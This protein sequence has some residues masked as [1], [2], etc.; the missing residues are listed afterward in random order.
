M[1]MHVSKTCTDTA[2]ESYKSGREYR[3]KRFLLIAL[4]S[5]LAAC[6][7]CEDAPG[8]PETLPDAGGGADIQEMGALVC[9]DRDGD[10]YFSGADCTQAELDCNDNS[11]SINP[12]A[13]EVCGD[14]L[15]NNCADGVDETCPC[16]TGELRLCSSHGDPAALSGPEVRC[17]SGVQR[18]VEGAW[19]ETC[20]SEVGPAEETCNN[21]DD[22]CDG[23]ADEDLRAPTGE[24]LTPDYVPPPEDC[25]PTGE[26][27][28]FD[29]DGDGQVDEGCSCAVPD[30]D[31]NL[32]RTGQPCYS[33]PIAS[34][35]VG[36]CRS[37]T[38]SCQAGAWGQCTGDT[39]PAMEVCGD[40]LDNDCDGI[41]DNGCPTC[42]ATET[43][44][45]LC[46]G[47]DNDC[48]GVIDEGLRNGCGGCGP[49]AA[50]DTCG[51]GLDNNCDGQVDESCLCTSPQQP[52][53]PGPAEA[54]GVGSCVQGTQRCEGEFFGACNGAVLPGLELCG[55]TGMG[56]GEDEDCDGQVD[57][58]C[59]CSE[60]ATRPCGS[61]AGV[62]VYGTQTCA[63]GAWGTCEG[64]TGPTEAEEATC[65]G[66][67]N[68]CDG[69]E[70]EGLFNAC[71]ECGP[72]PEEVCDNQDNDCDGMVDEEV[73]NACGQCGPVP[74]EIC[75]NQDNDCDGLFDEGLQNACGDCGAL[76][77]EVCDG[78]DND[79]DDAVDEG[80]D[81]QCGD[82]AEANG[83]V[84]ICDG[85]DQDC[86]A[87]I[88]EGTR[89]DCN[90]CGEVPEEICDNRDNDCDGEVDEGTRNA[91]G[92]CGILPVDECN[93]A[94][95]DCDGEIDEDGLNA[96]NYCAA[97]ARETCDNIDNDC[98]G[99]VDDNAECP[100]EG[101]S[102]INGE[103]VGTCQAGECFNGTICRD[104]FC[105]TPCNNTDCSAGLVCQNGECGD[106]CEGI[107]CPVGL[108]CWLGACVAESCEVSGCPDGQVCDRGVCTDD[109]CA[110]AAC[111]DEQGC[112]AGSCFD[113][114]LDV[115][116]PAGQTCLQGVCIVDDCA[117]RSCPSGELCVEGGCVDDPCSEVT[118]DPGFACADGECVNDPCLQ[119]H[120]PEATKC[121]LGDCLPVEDNSQ[122]DV[123]EGE[124][125]QGPDM[126]VPGPNTPAEPDGGNEPSTDGLVPGGAGDPDDCT[127]TSVQTPARSHSLLSLF[128][129]SVLGLIFV[130][131]RRR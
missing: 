53:F 70:D 6:G 122:V 43:E 93:G 98:N 67:D 59:G 113:T 65:D 20:E 56:N 96:C 29:D 31:P 4:A 49:V 114:C 47:E 125:D 92:S 46:D 95:D 18:C 15:D 36:E 127:C 21:I 102:C 116:C 76:P 24:C 84:E 13:Q 12:G 110:G 38:R 58:G 115:E 66:L 129:L 52:C 51:D 30:F 101:Q 22:D 80:F 108:G 48:D 69:R 3:M 87:V 1:S 27:N 37:G 78:Q 131:R 16:N 119:T 50:D 2:I 8:G 17:K 82:C 120:C 103:C 14:R 105:V 9:A 11:K 91:C 94:D 104:G 63:S 61:N 26:G 64:G 72:L 83:G 10:G 118:C 100:E 89:N 106:P 33:G 55:E 40:D 73:I 45:T 44:E 25:G 7:G 62:C 111:E 41:V 35:G 109:L 23:M 5:G 124:G 68:D 107:V 54:A 81:A 75:D 39:T 90:E 32:P 126:V 85:I 112:R 130:R 19:S 60:G 34:L 74:D 88:D 86:D 121:R 117:G 97:L 77:D 57:E 42:V 128:A 79:C 123:G 71:G 99:T 28:G